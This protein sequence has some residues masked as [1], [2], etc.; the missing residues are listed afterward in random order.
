MSSDFLKLLSQLMG[1][2]DQDALFEMLRDPLAIS[3]AA[4]REM[5]ASGLEDMARSLRG[6]AGAGAAH[7]RVLGVAPGAS[8][9]EV[10][11]AYREAAKRCHPD[12]GGSDQA[13]AAVNQAY[14]EIARERGW[15]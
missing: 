7:Y 3:D 13:M 14:E 8:D 10:R 4:I 11:K 9:D 12:C 5:L 6:E 2:G 15:R 1:K